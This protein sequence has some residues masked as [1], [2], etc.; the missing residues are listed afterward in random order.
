MKHIKEF[1]SFEPINEIWTWFLGATAAFFFYKF[2]KELIKTLRKNSRQ[3]KYSQM[4]P[5]EKEEYKKDLKNRTADTNFNILARYTKKFFEKGGKVKFSE[6]II[7]YIFELDDL[8][9]KIH[10]NE[11]NIRW[12][13]LDLDKKDELHL[14]KKH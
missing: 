12:N 1:N 10:K 3:N 8:V 13:Y 14:N 4:S 11:N 7:Y 6:N 9:I 5:Q 2:I